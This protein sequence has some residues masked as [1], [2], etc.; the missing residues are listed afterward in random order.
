MIM[1]FYVNINFGCA[2]HALTKANS[3]VYLSELGGFS[4]LKRKQR[5]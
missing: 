5:T 4:E 3:V 2:F 1:F